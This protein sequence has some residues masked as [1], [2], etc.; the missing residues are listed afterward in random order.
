M[1]QGGSIR[2]NLA[3]SDFAENR[4]TEIW[5]VGG[6]KEEIWLLL[7]EHWTDGG[8]N[9]LTG[10]GKSPKIAPLDQEGS[11]AQSRRCL[12]QICQNLDEGVVG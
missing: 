3:T 4:T 11:P 9:Q 2:A 1:Q 7:C 10:K 6:V 8:P 5:S 12:C